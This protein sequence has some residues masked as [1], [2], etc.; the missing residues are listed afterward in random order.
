MSRISWGS[1]VRESI[2]FIGNDEILQL[3]GPNYASTTVTGIRTTL[4]PYQ[5]QTLQALIEAEDMR[6]FS[7]DLTK[8]S[9]S[10]SAGV[11]SNP[12]GS[13]KTLILLALIIKKPK[14]KKYSEICAL[15]MMKDSVFPRPPSYVGIIRKRHAT[16]LR[17]T[18]ICV[19]SG[20]FMQW[21]NA[22]ETFTCLRVFEVNNVRDLETLI[23]MMQTRAINQ[24]HVVL[25]KNSKVSRKVELPI[26]LFSNSQR[27]QPY[28]FNVIAN[29]QVCWMRVIIDDVDI[30]RLPP[31]ATRIPALFTWYVSSTKRYVH[32][33]RSTAKFNTT[34][35]VILQLP[36]TYSTLFSNKVLFGLM[37]VR[38]DPDYIQQVNNISEPLFYA[39]T[40][41]NPNNSYIELLGAIGTDEA[42]MVSEMLNGD[43]VDTAADVLGIK[44]DSVADIFRI[45][46]GA[47]FSTYRDSVR[48]LQFIEE[49]DMESLP[50]FK[51]NPDQMDKYTK[52]DL[53]SFRE[54]KYKYPGLR[55][56]LTVTEKERTEMKEKSGVAIQRVKQNL[57][58]C[59]ICR[60]EIE[61]EVALIFVCCGIIVCD[62]CCFGVVF[63][64]DLKGTCG[65]CRRSITAKALIYLDENFDPENITQDRLSVKLKVPDEAKLD[66]AKLDEAKPTKADAII[67]I[68]R[69][70]TPRGQRA[71]DV[72]IHN[73][74]KGNAPGV[75]AEVTKVLVFANFAESL[76]LIRTALNDAKIEY[77]QLHGT[78][79]EITAI[80]KNFTD[81]PEPQLLLVNSA[82]HCAGLN[83]QSATDLVFA[84][85]ITD[86]SIESQVVGR[87]QRI[88]RTGQLRIHYL[89][90]ENEL[91][92]SLATNQIRYR[93]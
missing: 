62:A 50:P 25:I 85:K 17:P 13:G 11:L 43:A 16:I 54:I 90:Y 60:L 39:Y 66:E 1:V 27:R 21:V 65:N 15:P 36:Y 42:R 81:S 93:D 82:Q 59:A 57:G 51:D 31:D 29:M 45:I 84:H 41:V 68:I 7:F 24:Y 73:M 47:Q 71:I 76:R 63:N 30:V 61:D 49:V 44:T 32:P 23:E 40:F 58:S 74:M 20:V 48:I 33:S 19:G 83:L 91:A 12:M 72:N 26:Q 28:I 69:G 5:L 35:D 89:F 3:I 78:T 67:D 46:L 55:S 8:Y 88:G 14:V 2:D 34:Q 77:V 56:L 52:Q 10:I 9:G 4:Y 80:V 18:L 6:V 53:L 86:S 38:C 87:G 37:N 79:K 92:S 22:I 75:E 64:K 70:R